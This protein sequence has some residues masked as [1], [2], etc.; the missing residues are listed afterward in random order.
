[1]FVFTQ[2]ISLADSDARKKLR[3]KLGHAPP[4]RKRCKSNEVGGE[5]DERFAKRKR[6]R[7]KSSSSESDD[8]P[9]GP[10]PRLTPHNPHLP[11]LSQAPA[12][13]LP[14]SPLLNET[15]KDFVKRH[16]AVTSAQVTAS[17]PALLKR[18]QQHGPGPQLPAKTQLT[19]SK[20]SSDPALSSRLASW[21]LSFISDGAVSCRKFRQ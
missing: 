19:G 6:S 7:R 1:M 18:R 11:P 20:C 17:Q 2:N 12:A 3:V 9:P 13:K 21:F 14:V 15:E 16:N 10:G 8:M 5:V 4:A